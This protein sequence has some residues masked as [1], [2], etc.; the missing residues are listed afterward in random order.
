MT[1]NTKKRKKRK[2]SPAY[3]PQAFLVWRSVFDQTDALVPSQLV[4][5]DKGRVAKIQGSYIPEAVISKIFSNKRGIS[6]SL[7]KHLLNL[8]NHKISSLVPSL[9]LFRV[10]N[11]K[12]TPFYFPTTSKFNLNDDGNLSFKESYSANAAAIQS[13]SITLAGKNPYEASRK[14]LNAN[15]TVKVDNISVL[16]NAP[17]GY[18]NLAD[19]FVIRTSGNSSATLSVAGKSQP[20]A[21]FQ[22]SRNCRI[23][24]ILGYSVPKDGSFLQ[25]E[26]KAIEGNKQ[27]VNLFYSGHD[28]SMEQDGSATINVKYTGFLEAANGSLA[29]LISSPKQKAGLCKKISKTEKLSANIET[30]FSE[31]EEEEEE[32]QANVGD[33]FR[34]TATESFAKDEDEEEEAEEEETSHEDIVIAFREIVDFLYQ[35]N[36]IHSTSFKTGEEAYFG[37]KYKLKTSPQDLSASSLLAMADASD[38]LESIISQHKI[39]YFNFGD[40]LQAY[41]FKISEDLLDVSKNLSGQLNNE[42][43]NYESGEANETLEARAQAMVFLRQLEFFNILTANFSG[44]RN[45][46][47]RHSPSF[48]RNIADIPISLD[49]LYTHIFEEIGKPQFRFYGMHKFLSEFCTKLLNRSFDR[50]QGAD[51]IRDLTFKLTTFSSKDLRGRIME[52]SVNVDDIPS[53]GSEF[54][55]SSIQKSSEYLV[56]HQESTQYNRSPGTG[57]SKSDT[58]EG[59][60]H[61]KTSKNQG[62]LKTISFS[63]ISMPQREAY[64]VARAGDLYDELRLPHNATAEM[65]GNNLFLP[66]SFVYIDPNSLGFGSIKDKNSAAR[67]LG[68]GGYYTVESVTTQYS[69]GSMTT[70]LNLLFNAFPDTVGQPKLKTQNEREQLSSI[71][72]VTGILNNNR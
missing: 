8:E 70:S 14:F 64:L 35:N 26:V 63:K 57:N 44:M 51:L 46:S 34:L 45:E 47:K 49:T 39:H 6:T 11:N 7:D 17:Q 13:F 2:K 36:K 68:F 55:K 27:L 1:K 4:N 40:F 23:G 42:S 66:S 18:A 53:P 61:L 58:K 71:G 30:F 59:I 20:S 50:F 48:M 60:F 16:F 29:N 38:N 9:K 43:R 65:F 19:L 67:R 25:E 10:D 28:I 24:A 56:F 52:G 5:L 32:E 31:E 22:D 21:D 62:L 69:A 54:T 33:A 72:K 12:A 3:F 37:R 15:L 41:F